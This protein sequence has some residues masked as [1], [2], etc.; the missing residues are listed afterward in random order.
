MV[1]S[2]GGD[3]A[4]WI[5]QCWDSAGGGGL[6]VNQFAGVELC[7]LS[8]GGEGVFVGELVVDALLGEGVPIGDCAWGH[9]GWKWVVVLW[10]D[11]EGGYRS[12]GESRRVWYESVREGG[13]E[14]KTA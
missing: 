3:V 11:G 14:G 2:E 6:G 5:I 10:C 8:F 9:C 4:D 1:G 13:R 12:S 7:L